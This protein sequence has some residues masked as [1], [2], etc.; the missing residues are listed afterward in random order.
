MSKGGQRL[1]GRHICPQSS[2]RSRSKKI[3]SDGWKPGDMQRQS[4]GDAETTENF[5]NRQTSVIQIRESEILKR[6]AAT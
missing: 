4:V 2:E 3:N 5:C 6:K 1:F